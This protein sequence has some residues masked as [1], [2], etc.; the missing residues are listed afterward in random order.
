MKYRLA[1]TMLAITAMLSGCAEQ[2]DGSYHPASG[3]KMRITQQTYRYFQQ[4]QKAIGSS[5]P[6]AFA[7]SESGRKSFYFYCEDVVCQS[8]KPYGPE[9][10]R[11][12][13]QMGNPCYV[14]AY[15]NDIKVDYEVV[16]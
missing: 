9:A 14:F 3:E 4:Y 16:P 11:R 12:C 7:V 5:H 10:V 8:G 1:A 15:G 13:T 6:G 2:G